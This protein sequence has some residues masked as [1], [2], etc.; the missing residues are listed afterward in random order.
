MKQYVIDGLRYNDY[1]KLKDF[2]DSHLV[3]S[4]I[5]GIYWLE[6]DPEILTDIQREHVKCHPLVFG[7]MLEE[8]CL[9]CEFLVRTQKNIKCEC[10]AYATTDQRNWLID[11]VDAILERLDIHI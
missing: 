2:L 5:G 7:L 1:Q 3:S 6:L 9:S 11:Q 4:S 8:T 10:M